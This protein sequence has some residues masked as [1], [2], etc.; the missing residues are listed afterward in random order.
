MPRLYYQFSSA[1]FF[2][3]VC[4]NA[5]SF[6]YEISPLKR[7]AAVIQILIKGLSFAGDFQMGYMDPYMRIDTHD[8]V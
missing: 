8:N 1:A 4:V 7:Q 3:A 6:V 2:T 5:L